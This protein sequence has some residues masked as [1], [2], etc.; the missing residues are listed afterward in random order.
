[1]GFR[2]KVDDGPGA[3]L[4]QHGPHECLIR[5]IS[6]HQFVAR[7]AGHRIEIAHIAGVGQQV[8]GHNGV[9]RVPH[10]G[11]HEI[12]ADET[13]ASGDQDCGFATQA[14]GPTICGNSSASALFGR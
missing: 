2:R 7:I 13:R 11:Q 1:M 14:H 6:D 12:G 5:D 3:I 4:R 10:A 9:V 8:E